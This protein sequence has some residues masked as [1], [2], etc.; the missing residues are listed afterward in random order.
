MRRLNMKCYKARGKPGQFGG[1]GSNKGSKYKR[2]KW[3]KNNFKNAG[4]AM[5]GVQ[6]DADDDDK[7]NYNLIGDDLPTVAAEGEGKQI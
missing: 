5:Y 6:A 2:F 1:T 3:K 7:F 4:K